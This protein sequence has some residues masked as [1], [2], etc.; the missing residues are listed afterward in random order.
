MLDSARRLTVGFLLLF[1]GEL[2]AAIGSTGDFCKKYPNSG[3]CEGSGKASCDLCHSS[4]PSLNPYGEDIRNNL[5]GPLTEKIGEALSKIEGDDSDGDGASNKDEL[6][7]GGHPGDDK[8]IPRANVNL[9]YDI[10][11]AFKRVKAIYCGSSASYTEMKALNAAADAKAFLHDELS[12][13]L[14]S[15]YWR[16][17]AL[18]RLA[19]KKIQ[20]LA[21]VGIKGDV[22]IGDFGW[23]YRLFSYIMSGDRDARELL[24]ATYHIDENGKRVEG[25]VDLEETPQA[26]NTRLV[27]GGG[28]PLTPSR[29][30]GMMTTQWFLSF[31]TMFT[32]L[33]RNTA[34]QVYREY[35]GLD[36][37]KG[38]GLMPVANEPRDVDNINVKQEA[39]ANCHSTLDPLTYA[40]STYNGIKGNVS[41]TASNANGSYD[42][43]RQPWE[44]DGS[45]FGE[46]VK[47]LMEWADKARNSDA[48]KKNIAKMM[49]TQA[50][51]RD[52]MAHEAKEFEA[53]WKE[54]PN[55]KYSVNKLLHRF[56]DTKA[57]GGRDP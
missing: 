20:P 55:E 32:P 13:C 15:D 17:E 4:P 56:V 18:H 54:L 14:G 26:P 21:A 3:F 46:P 6:G 45:I 35:L 7:E 40:F 30:A 31:F 47:D 24:S 39:C 29:R 49:F 28:Q 2:Q 5:S 27:T 34:S 50:L 12:K 9:V 23:D 11:I 37:S 44:A 57:F 10:E 25:I 51:S 38:D 48:F 19:D 1:N 36:I 16:K 43:K 53:L 42:P 33:P 52:P 8:V 22:V 41:G